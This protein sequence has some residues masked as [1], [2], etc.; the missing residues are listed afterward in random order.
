MHIDGNGAAGMFAEALGV[1]ITTAVLTCAGC[2]DSGPFAQAQ[3]YDQGPGVVARCAT[4][5]AVLARLVRTPTDAWL[6][7]R[8]AR[9][10]RLPL[11][12]AAG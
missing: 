2:G 1:D 10:V 6:D 3:V 5:E 9:S 12:P 4:C 11:G 7:L 8:G